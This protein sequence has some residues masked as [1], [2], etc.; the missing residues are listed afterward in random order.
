MAERAAINAPLQGSA[1]DIIKAAMVQMPAEVRQYLILQVHD[2]LLFEIPKEKIQEYVPIIQKVME[3]VIF[4][5]MLLKVDV[6][7]GDNWGA[8]H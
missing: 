7:V 5:T 2:E 8:V 1:A 6:S 3:E 4:S